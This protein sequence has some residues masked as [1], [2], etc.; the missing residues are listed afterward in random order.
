MT[1]RLLLAVALATGTAAVG[2]GHDSQPQ[3]LD[4]LAR[5][6]LARIEGTIR[7]AG[8]KAP[9]E[10]VRDEWG[11][12]HIYARSTEDLF[13]AQGYVMAQDRLWQM[14]MWRLGAEGRLAEALGPAAVPRDRQTRLLK[15]RGPV[16][17]RELTTYHPEARAIM[18]AYVAGVNARIADATQSQTLPVEFVL[19]G[20][21][22]QPWT[23]ETLLLRQTT[24]GD[25]TAELQLARSVAQ[26]GAEEA[27]RRRNPDPFEPLVVPQGLDVAVI[28]DAVQAAT[29]AGGGTPRPQVLPEY[30]A[31]VGARGGDQPDGSVREPGSNN[32]VISGALSATGK[33]VVANDPH[34][35]V[36][37]PSLRYISHLNAPGWNVAG[38]S[39]PPFLGIAIGHNDRIGWGLTIVGT[40]Q[41]D[42]YVEELNP[43]NDNEAKW[44]GKWEPLRTVREEIK[45]KG[46]APETI[47]LK[48]SRH[49]PIFHIDK[50][51]HL[52][53][54][55]RS[56]L[57]EPGT[58]PYL[59]GLRLAQVRDCKSF[60]EAAA[61]W[62]SP[63]E[64]LICGDVDGNISWRPSALTPA[65]K[66][67]SGRLPVPGTGAYEWQGFR[68]DLPTELNP[69]RGF[70]ATANHNVQPVGFT[71]PFMFKTAGT[72]F[73][74]ITRLLQI[75]Q[76]GKKFTLEDHGRIQ[77]D[78]LSLRAAAD[79]KA[80]RG[81]TSS[82]ATVER[83]RQM[84]D[85]WDAVYARDSA[86]A[87]IYEAWRTAGSEGRGGR[88]GRG[89][90]VDVPPPHEDA[91][92]ARLKQ[93]IER[94]TKEMGADWSQW[95]WG[96]MHTRAFPHPFVAAFNIAPVERNGGAGTVAADGA[97]YREIFDVSNWD[98]SL[99]INT[100]G[101]SGQ[102]GSPFYDN[103]AKLWGDEKYFPLL[104]TRPAVEKG[105]RHRI[106]LTPR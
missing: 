33:P 75:F 29:R 16:D 45:V 89:G 23:I 87:A 86:P 35:E 81:W 1:G 25:A 102:P 55:L 26:L 42:V 105:A 60:L 85:T 49:G 19:T 51:R 44:N 17:D 59:A 36:A 8:L 104:F 54:A 93:A 22:P 68:K 58:A 10:V 4:A 73:E 61:Y 63:S 14:E 30:A 66:G 83:A 43:A 38:A 2:A 72:Q 53:Y 74:R 12:P 48:F 91:V 57:H 56:A 41:H 80:F 84:L 34:R 11:V 9:V 64:N 37:N 46:A 70:I 32:W 65:R 106:T 6:S 5:A 69:P 40:D 67:W 31:L 24:F 103:L 13:F 52:A 90:G 100:P 28:D 96:R 7:A 99:V 78:A 82:D 39:E 88:G 50:T 94:L 76:P 98:R 95:R 62:N 27:N 97:S 15:Y 47:E 101:Q 77:H 79:L 71:P 3:S 92:A 21:R 18:T 20:I